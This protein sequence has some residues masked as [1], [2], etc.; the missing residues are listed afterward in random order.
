MFKNDELVIPIPLCSNAFVFDRKCGNSANVSVEIPAIEPVLDE[1]FEELK[2]DKLNVIS[3][4]IVWPP[5]T[6]INLITG[7]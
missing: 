1:E 7:T 5:A 4:R 3:I 2:F 6:V